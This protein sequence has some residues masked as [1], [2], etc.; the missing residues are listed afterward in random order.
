MSKASTS[1]AIESVLDEAK[2]SEESGDI[3][4]FQWLANNERALQQA[5]A[6]EIKA[7]QEA[8]EA[9]LLKI[10]A[11]SSPY[12]PPG[13][14][15]R[16]LV[17]Q[18]FLPLYIRGNTKTLFD[19]IQTLLKIPA[20]PKQ[21]VPDVTRIAAVYCIGELMD[22]LGSQV[23]S[24]VANTAALCLKLNKS[25]N[26]IPLRYHALVTLEK[27]VKSAR[28]A[29]ADN[30]VRDIT[31]VARSGLS[32]KAL[33][34]VRAS[35]Q[36]LITLYPAN[37]GT[38]SP[39]EV[40]SL[41]TLS[42]KA[43]DAADHPTRLALSKLAAHLLSSTQVERVVPAVEPK[44]GKKNADGNEEDEDPAPAAH[45]FN[46]AA[47]LVM[48]PEEMFSQLSTHFNKPQTSHKT[49]VGIF[50]FYAALL[51]SLGPSFI[52]RNYALIVSHLMTEIVSH[53]SNTGTRHNVLLVRQLVALVLRDVVGV[54]MLSEQGQILAIQE[55]STSYLKRWPAMMPGQN[56]PTPLVL[57]VALR[58]VAGL[59][60]QLGNTP[61]PVQSALL[62]PL[63][64]L[65]TH[66]NHTVRVH[67]SSA[68]QHFCYSTPLQ[69]PKTLL[70]LVEALQHDINQLGNP[71]APSD[72]HRRTLGHAY[73]L[74]ALLALIPHRPLYVSYDI[75]TNVFYLAVQLLKG[76]GDH[77]VSIAKVE[78]EVAW[79][80][81][82][83]LM[84][85]GPHF[86]RAHL[87]QLL[88]LWRN[89]LPKPT[90]KE[91]STKR[92]PAEW[93]FMLQVRENALR[94][95]HHFLQHNVSTLVTADIARRLLS[96]LS[97]ALQF[98]NIFSNQRVEEITDAP[99]GVEEKGFTLRD[100][101]AL[102]R[103][104]IY[105]CC[106]LLEP[107]TFTEPSQTSFLQ[108][109]I[110][111]F[112][113]AD[114]YVG[115]SVQAAIASSSGSFTSIWQTFDGY[116]Y[117]VCDLM[118]DGID[119]NADSSMD[120]LNRD[121]TDASLDELT[122][123]PILRSLE[124][125]PLSLCQFQPSSD[126]VLVDN[127]PATT[128]AV[129]SAIRLFAHMFPA[130]DPA[131][132]ANTVTKLMDAIATCKPDRNPG[133]RSAV[134]FNAAI[135]LLHS[136]DPQSSSSR[137]MADALHNA[138]MSQSLSSFLKDSLVDNDA[139]L[140]RVSSEAIG[141]LANL[142]GTSFLTSQVKN[143][144]NEVVANRDPHGRAG[145]ALAFGAIHG[146]VGGLA[147][148]PLL[149]TTVHV[150]M[151]L[152]NDPHPVVHFW[153]LK[154]LA[155]VIDAAS[156]TYAS[157]VP[158]T[159]GLLFKTYMSE[160]HEPEGGPLHYANLRG[161]LPAYQV[162]C[163]NIDAIITIVGPDLQESARTRTM[164]L[165]LVE[166][167]LREE[168]EGTCVEALRC[169]Q[170]VLMFAPDFVNIPKLVAQFRGYLSS[171]RRLLKLAS[172]NALYQILQKDAVLMSRLGGDR[173]VEELFAMLD[174]DWSVSG[175][176]DVI[177]VWLQQTAIY[178]PSAWI[179][180]CQRIM[181]HTTA[182]QQLSDTS[183]TTDLDDEGQS[184]SVSAGGD[185]RPTARWRTQLFALQCLH[186][187]CETVI[188]SGI[189]EQL[190][191]SYAEAH[192]HARSKLLVSRIADL[193]KMAFTA[194]AT[195]VTEIRVAGLRVLQDVIEAFASVPDPD[196]PEASIL[197]QYQ[198]PITAALMP[199]FSSDSTAELLASAIKI[200]AIFVSSGIVKEVGRMGR[201]MKVLTSGLEQCKDSAVLRIGDAAD[202]GPNASVMLRIAVLT[203]WAELKIAS[204][205][206]QYLSR[207]LEPY[208]QD[209]AGLWIASL[210]DYASI[211]VGIE[212]L[213]DISAGGLDSSHASLGRE[214]LLPYYTASWTVILHAVV[215]S[216]GEREPHVQAAIRGVTADKSTPQT[217]EQTS[218]FF[219]VIFGLAF[220]LL[221]DTAISENS[222]QQPPILAL[223]AFRN[224]LDKKYCGD[225]LNDPVLADELINL[226]YR[227]AITAPLLYLPHVT[228][229]LVQLAVILHSSSSGSGKTDHCLKMAFLIFKRCTT[230][231][232]QVSVVSSVME[233]IL[234][235]LQIQEAEQKGE[236]GIIMLAIYQGLLENEALAL[237]IA[238]TLQSLGQLL[239]FVQKHT[240]A[241]ETES[242]LHAFLSGC[243]NNI[244][245]TRDRKGLECSC[246][247]KN[248]ML[249]LV[250][251]LTA[252]ATHISIGQSVIEHACFLISQK[253]LELEDYS[254]CAAQCARTLT[255][256]S[257]SGNARL[258]SCATLLLSAMIE[259]TFKIAGKL[260]NDSYALLLAEIWKTFAAVVNTTP[261]QQKS[262]ILGL[263]LP[264]MIP[265]LQVDAH[266][267]QVLTQ[268]LSFAS[269]SPVAF[270]EATAKLP[271]NLRETLEVS[272][273]QAL[274][275]ETQSKAEKAKPQISLKA[276]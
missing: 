67:A 190:D 272:V 39:S 117:G 43:L 208:K 255:V 56:A 191:L 116:A 194:S 4:L 140:R 15:I 246:K 142:A 273:K 61:S 49:R 68:L 106:S 149:K 71:A 236:L 172:I 143:L 50:S 121:S 234:Q 74:S 144:V 167:F 33:P 119:A 55:L 271:S 261:E 196:Y 159:L 12:P 136:F 134:V 163:Q 203:A 78:V 229:S 16:N 274:G 9:I 81:I 235:I 197:E 256:A 202:I 185:A 25:S 157:F 174:D 169:M 207:L 232:T 60:Q 89:A 199:A 6:D 135:A 132:T 175:V 205:S 79:T 114:G 242:L 249:A 120:W 176:R 133:R 63:L 181:S 162:V 111:L 148:G 54:R 90:T 86:V 201:I 124:H 251:A 101:E 129:D 95:I 96:L 267:K 22:V 220:E 189:R 218:P 268:I 215:M 17:A 166:L 178:N 225:A 154:A 40:E 48:S 73:G 65:L 105:Q 130:Q 122:R 270:K 11:G 222:A 238:P 131:S 137:R 126:S 94:A 269:A 30:V 76:A 103:S 161:D 216:M 62:E 18:C 188:N 258:S 155:R 84:C 1:A 221:T 257:L 13:R 58:E 210:R 99:P 20:E 123:K 233:S 125:D 77:D 29:L 75:N 266:Q 93:T 80:L 250:L 224:L 87:P 32:D 186:T 182:S 214:V 110:T 14:P 3:F 253:L 193:I 259:C 164:I 209:L 223:E 26:S 51:S 243:L 170:H 59:V 171:S 112:A 247:V 206:H 260:A 217:D 276:F 28:R 83:S 198:A 248:N 66:P 240:R 219:F 85:L 226:F 228:K 146:H 37:D 183:K 27:T 69:L 104:R 45:G 241:E 151:S 180:I 107:T 245:A 42:V 230:S 70:S 82:A 254:M 187:I 244:D 7:E 108:S 160:S 21:V 165:D 177:M 147:A 227:L 237:D 179:D 2:L 5:S 184:L 204:N 173:F 35:A 128:A 97:N 118:A 41:V 139:F 212:G 231:K 152:I 115:S 8:L 213:D 100:V 153:S 57:T 109:A 38:R 192:G 263:V 200:C 72:I 145:C 102:L 262:R 239:T 150:L 92:S 31:K 24:Q 91:N 47:K 127:P 264:P 98:T 46:T 141:R 138:Q 34:V 113:G 44:K 275:G 168:S 19:T 211:K 64:T 252:S 52:E 158:S 23:M 156:L 265:L 53:S 10:I 88:V 195:H 36:L